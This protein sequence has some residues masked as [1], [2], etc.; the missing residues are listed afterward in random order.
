MRCNSASL[1]C[2]FAVELVN[3]FIKD[4]FAGLLAFDFDE[5]AKRLIV[6]NNWEGFGAKLLQTVMKDL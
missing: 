1:C 3:D 4:C 5:E 6:L 2:C